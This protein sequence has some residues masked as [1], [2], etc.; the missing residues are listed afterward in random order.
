MFKVKKGMRGLVVGLGKSGVAATKL[1][2]KK[3]V[4]VR[5]TDELNKTDLK[6][7]LDQLEGLDFD[8]ELGKHVLKSFT[9][10]DF[11]VLSPGVRRDIKPLQQAEKQ[12]VPVISELEL[13]AQFV[14]DPIIAVTGTNGK[15]TTAA[16]IA[17][18]LSTGGKSVFLGGSSGTPLSEYACRREKADWVVVEVSSFQL[19]TTYTLKPHIA[20]FL[21]VAPDHLDRYPTFDQYVETKLR[22]KA[23][24]TADDYVVTNLR[25]A[26]LMAGLADT[27]AKM[28][29]FTTDPWARVPQ[30]YQEKFQGTFLEPSSMIHLKTQ[31]WKEHTFPLQGALLRGLHNRENMMAATLAAKL[32]GVTNESIQKVLTKFKPLPHRLEPIGRR[33]QVL[34]VNDSKGTNVHALMRTLEA[35]QEPVI[36]IAGGKDKGEDFTPLIPFVRRHVK[37][38]ILIGESK[39]R[40]NR[41]IGDFSETFLVGTFEEAVYVAYQKSRSGDVVLLSPGCSSQDMFKSFEERGERFRRLVGTF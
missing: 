14:S 35:F 36:L 24:L 17:E 3:G 33:N 21:N 16:L 11:I 4:K 13:A 8:L 9:D 29:T 38:L 31:R 40:M 7:S 41:A 27:Q 32:A 1:L 19:E 10:T 39:E 22:L 20:I 23:N 34:F 28:L 5:V 2:C 6:H 26:K 30:H 12:K 25:D 37:N 15:T 18:M